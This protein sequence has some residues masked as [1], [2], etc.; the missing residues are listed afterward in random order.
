MQRL[1]ELLSR[2]WRRGGRPTKFAAMLLLP[3]MLISGCAAGPAAGVDVCAPWQA[4]YLS[5]EDRLTTETARQV[6]AHNEVGERLC[7]WTPVGN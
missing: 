4:I 2:M 7:R 1:D 6:V 5:A 3:L